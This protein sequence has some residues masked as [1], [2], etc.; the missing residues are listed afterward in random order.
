[1][2]KIGAPDFCGLSHISR[3]TNEMCITAD[4]CFDV[5]S[6]ISAAGATLGH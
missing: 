2:T 1:M 3:K 5:Q 6:A 4:L